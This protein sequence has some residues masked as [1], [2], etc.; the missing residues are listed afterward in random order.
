MNDVAKPDQGLNDLIYN[1]ATNQD[2]DI[3]KF[4]KI[5]E[6]KNAEEQRTA[7]A[8][9]YQS[10]PQLQAEMPEISEDGKIVVN[11]QV[12]S[13]YARYEDIVRITKPL[14]QKHGFSFHAKARFDKGFAI[15]TGI[16]AHQGGHTE[17]TETVLPFDN[18]GSK[19]SVQ[20]IGSSLSYAR[21]YLFTM[22]FNIT[23][24]GEDDNGQKAVG[25]SISE[26]QAKSIKERLEETGSDV[27]RFLK[28]LGIQNIDSMPASLYA[29]ADHALAVKESKNEKR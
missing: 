16:V 15:V 7:K 5:I 17:E 14:L 11:G 12:R 3:A 25:A 28:L 29:K 20:A 22:L 27:N 26:E 6:L 9:Y 13:T 23:T 21:R 4:E 24:G 10:M 8:A 19:N 2:L 1:L 18:T